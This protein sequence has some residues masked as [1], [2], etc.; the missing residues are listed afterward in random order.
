M[1]FNGTHKIC[2]RCFKILHKASIKTSGSTKINNWQSKDVRKTFLDFFC[3]KY[4][5]K[6]VPSSSVI[7][8]K[9][10]GTYFTNAGMNQVFS[11]FFFVFGLNNILFR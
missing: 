5:H 1:Q 6:F 2:Q 4:D 10:E 11:D 9:G 7:P 3:K 8:K